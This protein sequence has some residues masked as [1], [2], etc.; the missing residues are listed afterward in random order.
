M[1]PTTQSDDSAALEHTFTIIL[2]KLP[3]VAGSSSIPPFH[4]C[5]AE[6]GVSNASDFVSLDPSDYG[7]IAFAVEPS[8]PEDQNLTLIQVKKINSLFSWFHQVSPAG[9]SPWM[10][11]DL[12]SVQAW[13]S[14]PAPIPQ[15]ASP[16]SFTAF[17]CHL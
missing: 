16:A 11:L 3:P 4:A 10:D 13:C 14:L 15:G 2:P 5:L 7:I 12:L 6:V 17:F 1:L 9:V 8:G